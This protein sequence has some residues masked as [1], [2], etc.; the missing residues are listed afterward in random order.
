MLGNFNNLLM[1]LIIVIFFV[2]FMSHSDTNTYA[3]IDLPPYGCEP[4]RE[5][6][7][8][9]TEITKAV[10]HAIDAHPFIVNAFPYPRALQ[11]FETGKSKVL[12]ALFN[13]RLMAQANTI[14]LYHGIFYVVEIA[15][16]VPSEKHSII[17]YLHGADAQKEIASSIN[18]TPF[19]ANNYN[20]IV[21]MLKAN[22][23]DYAIIP[24]FVYE[25]EVRGIIGNAHIL[26]E[27]R[28]PVMLYVNKSASINIKAI[29]DAVSKLE[30]GF[31]NKYNNIFP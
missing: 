24:R 18:A 15:K 13:K 19:E 10:A 27:H 21:S 30:L 8:I 1:T 31:P 6:Y 11:M 9:N 29:Q 5:L 12:V 3:V 26:S 22:R 25:S 20:Q 17:S 23:L 14:H 16:E 28:L 2:P 7:C 4:S